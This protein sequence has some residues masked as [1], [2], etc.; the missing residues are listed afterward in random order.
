MKRRRDGNVR[1]QRRK[2]KNNQRGNKKLK[3]SGGETAA[4]SGRRL[5]DEG[6]THTMIQFSMNLSQTT[7]TEMQH[8]HE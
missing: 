6:R 1:M 4:W 3:E 5:A 8:V 2:Q 7:L